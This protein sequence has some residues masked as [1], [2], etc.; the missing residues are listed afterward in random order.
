MVADDN[1]SVAV[2]TPRTRPFRRENAL[3][4]MLA[5]CVIPYDPA[6]PDPTQRG[7][8]VD[9]GK[10]TS[11]AVE[12][13]QFNGDQVAESILTIV[14]HRATYRIA[15]DLNLLGTL[16]SNVGDQVALCADREVSNLYG[17]PGGATLPVIAAL[18]LHGEP[19]LADL[20]KRH[21]LHIRDIDLAA[22]GSSGRISL[23]TDRTYFLRTQIKKQDG[24]LYA[25][26]R[27]WLRVPAGTPGADAIAS[28]K[29]VWIVV[30]KPELVSAPDGGKPKLVLHAV[31]AV[32][33][34]FP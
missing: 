33:E 27:W 31:E 24:E 15:A 28:G 21:A 26:D 1:P 7:T 3:A 6:H 9:W 14:G 10:V 13:G 5:F 29:P 20:A 25:M 17:F 8:V 4:S 16:T 32:P 19:Q 23:A 18:P 30:D 22:Q 11:S 34:I 2:S 12:R